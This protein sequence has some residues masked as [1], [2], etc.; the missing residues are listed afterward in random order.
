[1]EMRAESRIQPSIEVAKSMTSIVSI[2]PG[3][4]KAKDVS[5]TNGLCS[6]EVRPVFDTNRL[7][8]T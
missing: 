7:M 6:G 3:Y 8:P 5:S 2:P 4:S 1:M